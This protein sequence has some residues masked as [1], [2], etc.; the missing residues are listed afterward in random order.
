MADFFQ[1][2]QGGAHQ[3]PGIGTRIGQGDDKAV[4]VLRVL[5]AKRIGMDKYLN[6]VAHPI[7]GAQL[8]RAD[9]TKVL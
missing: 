9:I 1:S 7:L 6:G 5:F 8:L 4:A 3:D 2:E